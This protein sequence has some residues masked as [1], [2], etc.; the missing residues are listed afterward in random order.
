MLSASDNNR[1]VSRPIQ[2]ADFS[3]HPP[4]NA[5]QCWLTAK[6]RLSAVV[7]LLREYTSAP[8]LIGRAAAYQIES[9]GKRWRPLFLLAVGEALNGSPGDFQKMAAATELLHNASLVHDD[10]QDN[11]TMRRGKETVWYRFGPE[12]AI[13]LGDFLISSTYLALSQIEAPGDKLAR[14][15][16]HFAQATHQII[17]GQSMEIQASR[18]FGLTIEDYRDIVRSKSGVLMALPVVGAMMLVQAP[19]EMCEHAREA[20]VSLGTA[21]QIKDDLDDLFG[22][23]DGR[24]AGVDLREGRISLPNLLFH[25]EA[26]ERDRQAFE[27][28]FES[29]EPPAAGELRY[30]VDR[31]RQSPVI[32][33][34]WTEFEAAVNRASRHI[35]AL[36]E[37]LGGVLDHGK[38]IL[39]ATT[40]SR[41]TEAAEPSAV[42]GTPSPVRRPIKH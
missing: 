8:G 31:L 32:A 6:Q 1:M 13:N 24:P 25:A 26:G 37:L 7:I 35:N 33:A 42:T 30:W 38:Q 21:Y 39:L 18:Q 14:L 27:A 15:V 17:A 3:S 10:L 12:T 9:G 29:P 36:P 5:D 34:C 41:K 16:S 11:D 28:F 4:L 2:Q 22:L 20:M 23:K 19:R 40:I